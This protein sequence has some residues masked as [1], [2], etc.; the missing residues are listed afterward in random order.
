MD[1][2]TLKEKIRQ[3]NNLLSQAYQFQLEIERK[4]VRN[5]EEL[6]AHTPDTIQRFNLAT[7]DLLLQSQLYLN[8]LILGLNP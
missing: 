6:F 4:I 1:E 3:V 2:L 5:G 7:T 8:D